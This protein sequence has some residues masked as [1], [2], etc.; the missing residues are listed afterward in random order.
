MPSMRSFKFGSKCRR[1][2]MKT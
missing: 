1:E 2:R